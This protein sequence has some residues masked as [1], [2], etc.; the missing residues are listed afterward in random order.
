MTIRRSLRHG[1]GLVM[2]AVTL[3][4]LLVLSACGSP[5]PRPTPTPTRTPRSALRAT[6]TPVPA[7]ATPIPQPTDTPLPPAT[8]T[9]EPPTATPILPTI[10]PVSGA[11]TGASGQ[12]STNEEV[13]IL[14]PPF[15]P[16]PQVAA[17]PDLPARE[18]NINPLTGLVV[19]PAKLTVRPLLVC[20]NNDPQANPQ[21]GF[22]QADLVYEYVMES[23]FITRFTAVF[24]GQDAERIGPVRSARLINA[25]LTAQFDG[26]LACSGGS[27]MVRW[28]LKHKAT[29]PYLDGD[30]DDPGNNRYYY[31]VGTDYRTRLQTTTAGLRKWLA[32][33]KLEKKVALRGFAFSADVPA[34]GTPATSIHIPYPK[35]SKLDNE[36]DWTYNASSGRYL[37][38]MAGAPHLDAATKEQLSAANVV[39]QF[40]QHTNTDIKED[41]LG[42][43]SVRIELWG[44]GKAL[45]FRDGQVI[46]AIWR[47]QPDKNTAYLYP[48]GRLISFKPGNTWFEIVPTDY[49]VTYK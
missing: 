7:T 17:L 16:V 35:F 18:A 24:W 4:G 3:I 41:S 34:G 28:I 38:N 48:D 44:E 45:V 37:R 1:R 13:W 29:F 19:D 20:I 23:Y 31:S 30:L 11:Q 8:D 32:D 47:S 12:T 27:D 33:Q 21:Y 14:P 40:A 26:L 9:P 46:E 6:A 43:L 5:R 2:L 36:V 15:G 22:A 42:S 10:T 25:E 49:K 39:V